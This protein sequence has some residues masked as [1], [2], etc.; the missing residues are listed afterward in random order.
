MQTASGV[1]NLNNTIQIFL[2]ETTITLTYIICE[3]IIVI[4]QGMN[5]DNYIVA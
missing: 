4:N 1:S 3:V 2:F 5:K